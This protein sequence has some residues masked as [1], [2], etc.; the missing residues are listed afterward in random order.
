MELPFE[1]LNYTSY[2][3]VNL[4]SYVIGIFFIAYILLRMLRAILKKFINKSSDEMRVDPTKY[5]FL[6]NALGFIIYT[7]ALIVI[8]LTIDE[9]KTLGVT[10][11]AGAGIIAAIIG[12]ASQAAFSNIVSGIFIVIFQPFRVGDI[13]K[14]SSSYSG[15]VEDIT[16]RHTVI[17]DFENKRLVIPN[18]V[19]SAETIH[20]FNIVDEKVC[21]HIFYG[22]SYDSDIDLAIKIIQQEAMKHRHFID[23][24]SD[25]DKARKVSPVV[26]RLIDFGES[27]INL[28]AS[29]WTEDPMKGF[30]LKCDINK[31]IKERFDR[32]GIEIPFPYRTI[33]YKE[34]KKKES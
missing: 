27:S 30:E 24:R 18:S 34:A 28:R 31:S 33:V 29:V 16:L 3:W 32:E 10:L 9:L 11:F 15:V 23:Q 13:V 7:I 6:S 25:E 26:V 1:F 8:F 12:F 4:A 20:N 5:T 21:N 22:I 2:G 17:R 19:I 14:I